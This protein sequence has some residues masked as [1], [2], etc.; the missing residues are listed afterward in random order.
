MVITSSLVYTRKKN[1]AQPTYEIFRNPCPRNFRISQSIRLN[2]P[3]TQ[4]PTVCMTFE[5]QYSVL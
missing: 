5:R 4:I 3:K 2:T 1:Y